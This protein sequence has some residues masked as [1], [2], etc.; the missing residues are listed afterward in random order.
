MPNYL[1][2]IKQSVKKALPERCVLP[3]RCNGG[4]K[5]GLAEDD[6]MIHHD[7]L[8]YPVP[9]TPQVFYA[10]IWLLTRQLKLA[11]EI[12]EEKKNF[13]G[14]QE[15]FFSFALLGFKAASY[16]VSV[17]A[18]ID[19][20]A[21]GIATTGTAASDTTFIVSA[22]SGR[23]LG[24]KVSGAL[25]RRNPFHLEAK[26]VHLQN[27]VSLKETLKRLA[28]SIPK[29]VLKAAV[30]WEQMKNIFHGIQ[31]ISTSPGDWFQ[32]KYDV[33]FF[34]AES[35]NAMN[36]LLLRTNLEHHVIKAQ[37]GSILPWK[38]TRYSTKIIKKFE[39]RSATFV[40][41]LQEWEDK[42]NKEK[43]KSGNAYFVDQAPLIKPKS[44]EAWKE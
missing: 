41:K 24:N 28:I 10:D 26:P 44:R 17:G 18:L 7:D 21:T 29:D 38:K 42:Q 6:L 14:L 36:Q 9:G 34:I 5:I 4:N 20:T 39:T 15:V 35:L 23:K 25:E 3:E 11:T 22:D 19:A 33:L 13:H 16:A 43:I 2:K 37:S 12:I 27:K 1:G 8:L 31:Q 40:N 32:A 30:G